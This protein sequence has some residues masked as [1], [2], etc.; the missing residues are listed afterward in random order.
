[1]KTADGE[2]NYSMTMQRFFPRYG[3]TVSMMAF[4][5]NFY[6]GVICL[7]QVLSQ[8]LYPIILNGMGS[9]EQP[10][11]K[12]DWSKFSLS[13]TCLIVLGIVLLLTAPRDTMYI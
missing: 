10:D 7:F 13:Y 5:F 8:S 1:M 9:S 11:L 4:I 2:E 12:A 3:W 6:S